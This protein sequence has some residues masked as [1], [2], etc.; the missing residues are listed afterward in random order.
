MNA[1]TLGA[2]II[3]SDQAKISSRPFYLPREFSTVIISV[4]YIPPP[5]DTDMALSDLHDVLCRFPDP[6]S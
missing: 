3:Q 6:T 2:L 1:C 4:V 5:A